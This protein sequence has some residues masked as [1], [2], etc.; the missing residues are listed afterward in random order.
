MTSGN[1][2]YYPIFSLLEPEFMSKI[3]MVFVY[4]NLGNEGLIVTEDGM[5]YALGNNRSGCLGTGDTQSTLYPRIVQ[6]LCLKDIKTFACG[7]GPHVL[8]LTNKGE[9]YSWGCNRYSQLGRPS[10]NEVSCI[11]T[12]VCINLNKNIVVDIACGSN[13]SLALIDNGEIYAWG[14]NNFGQA[15]KS[16][17]VDQNA[18]T[19]INST[20]SDKKFICISCGDSFCIAVTDSGEVYSWGDN[21]EGQLGI[22][23]FKNQANPCKVSTLTGIIIEKV[24]CGY[25]HTL[26][27][28]NKGVLYVWGGNNNG[29]LGLDS[30]RNACFPV[31]LAVSTVSRV[32]DVAANHDNNISVAMAEG[33]EIFIWGNCLGQCINSP[34][35]TSLECMHDAFAYYGS[36]RVMYRPLIPYDKEEFTLMDSLM[37]A[38]D[39]STTSD[40]TIRV[41]GKPIHVHMAVLKIRCQYFK[42]MFQGN[43]TENNQSVIEYCE[44]SYDVYRAFL[45][46]LYTDEVDLPA[47][48]ALELLNLANVYSVDHLKRRCIK[49]IEKGITVENVLVLCNKAIEYEITNI[50][51]YCFNFA[52]K[53]MTAVIQSPKFSEINQSIVNTFMNKAAQ[54]GACKGTWFPPDE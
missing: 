1:L 45:R 20:L 38:F 25:K 42:T 34:L 41:Q 11:P 27:L 30:I 43:L 33:T 8:A 54:A 5:T 17:S 53:H 26:A 16:E 37:E 15:G 2:R 12:L 39:D 32:L 18:P 49:I 21:S 9:V 6:A 29:E 44:F 24:V 19:K 13:H 22:G 3:H 40:L 7:S 14:K 23:N 51:E 52:V 36:P 47:E 50:E 46:Y 48:S 31:K 28:S 4:G 35:L 10:T